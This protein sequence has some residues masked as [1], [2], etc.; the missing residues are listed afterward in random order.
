M[1][2]FAEQVRQTHQQQPLP[3]RVAVEQPKPKQPSSRERALQFAAAV[4]K[5]V[6]KPR[7]VTSASSAAAAAA[8]A[9]GRADDGRSA[10]GDS[11]WV[12]GS[13][14][15]DETG[16]GGESDGAPAMSLLQMLEEQHR[17]DVVSVER[18]R[19]EFYAS[20]GQ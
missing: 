16:G 19:A 9:G 6:V 20:Q 10:G 14:V 17:R 11:E 12:I 1:L 4:P 18:I 2:E 5:P 7:K 15:S 3:R 13:V 8:A